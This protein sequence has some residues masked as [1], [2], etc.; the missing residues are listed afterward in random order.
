MYP[1]LSDYRYTIYAFDQLISYGNPLPF[2][3]LVLFG[4]SFLTFILILTR[5]NLSEFKIWKFMLWIYLI[6]LLVYLFIGLQAVITTGKIDLYILINFLISPFSYL[7]ILVY[8]LSIKT[9]PFIWRIFLVI[10]LLAVIEDLV[11]LFILPPNF[12]ND[13]LP[14]KWS[15]VPL[16]PNRVFDNLFYSIPIIYTIYQLSKGRTIRPKS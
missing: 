9:R 16:S 1:R 2:L 13:L 5:K 7:G 3:S 14:V 4:I 10:I 11:E 6:I 8:L 12:L 15:N